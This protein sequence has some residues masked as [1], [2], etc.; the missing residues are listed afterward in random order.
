[1]SVVSGHVRGETATL[2]LHVEALYHEYQTAGAFAAASILALV[3][4]L[5][6]AGKAW[7]ERR[8]AR[9][10]AASSEAHIAPTEGASS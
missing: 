10:R 2:P 6:L 8:L 5:T 7:L 3:A 1:V 9:A 4:L